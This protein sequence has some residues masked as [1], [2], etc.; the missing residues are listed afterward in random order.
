MN[1]A[2]ASDHAG[3]QFK[4]VLKQVLLEQG[5]RVQDFG[6]SSKEA[7]DY[8]DYGIPAAESVFEQKNERAILICGNGIGMSIS[9]KNTEGVVAAVVYSKKTARETR[10]HHDSNVLCLGAREFDQASLLDF[11][12]I[13]LTTE[14]SGEERHLRRIRKALRKNL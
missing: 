13:W 8:P 9:A 10:Q 3:F 4:E 5:H 1:I 7:C 6:C 12:E 2:I 14:F 11:V